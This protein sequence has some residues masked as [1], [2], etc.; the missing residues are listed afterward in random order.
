VEFSSLRRKLKLAFFLAVGFSSVFFRVV[1]SPSHGLARGTT[2][3][4]SSGSVGIAES[5]SLRMRAMRITVL[6]HRAVLSGGEQAGQSGE[7]LAKPEN[8]YYYRG[9]EAVARVQAW[10]PGASRLQSAP[11]QRDPRCDATDHAAELPIPLTPEPT[12]VAAPAVSPSQISCNASTP[13]PDPPLQDLLAAQ[14]VVLVGL[15]AHIWGVRYKRTSP[16]R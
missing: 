8:R 15:I 9:P 1:Y 13:A 10:A 7:W 2:C 4:A 6:L 12:P 11:S 16:R 5:T 3:E 14:P